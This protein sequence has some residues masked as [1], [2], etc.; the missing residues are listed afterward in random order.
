VRSLSLDRGVG[1]GV[2][3]GRAPGTPLGAPR[4]LQERQGCSCSGGSAGACPGCDSDG[5]GGSTS[6]SSRASGSC[7]R[8]HAQAQALGE[9]LGPAPAATPGSST[10]LAATATGGTPCGGPACVPRGGRR[11]RRRCAAALAFPSPPRN[12]SG[13]AWELA[14]P[15]VPP[16]PPL[17]CLGSP[18]SGVGPIPS[19]PSTPTG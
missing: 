2:S 14:A 7:A 15:T 3:V 1:V 13:S 4:V 11:A 12:P 16:T 9:S 18:L 8:A 19:V 5:V 6:P 10:P 17:H